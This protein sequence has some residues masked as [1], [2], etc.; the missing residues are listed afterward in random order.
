MS[1]RRERPAT[2]LAG[3]VPPFSPP[4]LAA[5]RHWSCSVATPA[6]PSQSDRSHPPP[7][8]VSVRPSARARQAAPPRRGSRANTAH[9]LEVRRNTAS[10]MASNWRSD[11]LLHQRQDLV[12]GERAAIHA[13]VAHGVVDVDDADDSGRLGNGGPGQSLRIA[14]A[15]PAARGGSRRCRAPWRGSWN[16]TRPASWPRS[17]CASS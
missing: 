7:T 10:S 6:A 4:P 17:S 13:V 11:S 12:L 15:V 9:F 2:A 8:P 1:H 3:E 5:G 14:R 16:A